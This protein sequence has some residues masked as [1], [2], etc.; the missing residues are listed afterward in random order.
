M[1]EDAE[2]LTQEVWEVYIAMSSK[3]GDARAWE[4]ILSAYKGVIND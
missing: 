3:F 1:Y 4:F 2:D